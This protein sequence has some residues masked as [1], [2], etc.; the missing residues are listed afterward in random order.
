MYTFNQLDRIKGNNVV[1]G[2]IDTAMA[3]IP[4]QPSRDVR[5]IHDRYE[6]DGFYIRNC[7]EINIDR[8]V[9]VDNDLCYYNKLSV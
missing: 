6:A 5:W 2:G 7:Y 4:Y 3:L 8:H 9:Y 1:V